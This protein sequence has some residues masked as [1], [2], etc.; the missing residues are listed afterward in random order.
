MEK[1]IFKPVNMIHDGSCF[2]IEHFLLELIFYGYYKPFMDGKGTRCLWVT[3]TSQK[4]DRKKDNQNFWSESENIYYL[5]K[6]AS[7]IEERAAKKSIAM[8]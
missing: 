5:P 6:F 1:K 2:L 4:K 8:I 7:N 3:L